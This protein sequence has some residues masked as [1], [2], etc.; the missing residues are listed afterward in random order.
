MRGARVGI[1]VGVLGLVLLAAAWSLA[2]AGSASSA[3][4]PAPRAIGPAVPA[5][6]L[7]QLQQYLGNAWQPARPRT[8][9]RA[10]PLPRGKAQKGTSCLVAA[11]GFCSITPC[12]VPVTTGA[13]AGC[14]AGA[15]PARAFRVSSSSPATFRLT[16]P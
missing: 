13:G 4:L 12:V 7:R 16:T 14:P 5:P 1:A 8:L 9:P 15:P 11:G 10:L 2:P 3:R 6:L